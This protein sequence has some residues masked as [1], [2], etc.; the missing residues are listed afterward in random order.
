MPA[1][2]LA[3][4][5][6]VPRS[7]SSEA[8]IVANEELTNTV[9]IEQDSFDKGRRIEGSQC[10]RERYDDGVVDTGLGDNLELLGTRREEQRRGRW[11]HDLQGVWIEGDEEARQRSSSRAFGDA[12]QEVAMA[13]MDAVERADSYDGAVAESGKGRRVGSFSHAA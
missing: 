9:S 11:I 12:R 5:V 7:S 8:V 13:E 6:N 4:H 3:K 2:K 1:P 10:W